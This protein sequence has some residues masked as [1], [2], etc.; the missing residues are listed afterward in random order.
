MIGKDRGGGVAFVVKKDC[1]SSIAPIKK[2]E[3]EPI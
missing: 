1:N 3:T 2:Q